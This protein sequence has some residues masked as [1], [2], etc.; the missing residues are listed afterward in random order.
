MRRWREN[1][2]EGLNATSCASFPALPLTKLCAC[3]GEKLPAMFT[4]YP[5]SFAPVREPYRIGLQFTHTNGDFGAKLRRADVEDGA[6]AYRISS[7][8]GHGA[9]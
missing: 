7:V 4:Q 3:R 8:S 9:V 5:I 1:A 6:S 2:R